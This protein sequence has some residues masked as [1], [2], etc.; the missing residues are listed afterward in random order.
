[1]ANGILKSMTK[2]EKVIQILK[3][4]N[5][6]EASIIKV[7]YWKIYSVHF[8]GENEMLSNELIKIRKNLPITTKIIVVFRYG[9][10]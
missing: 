6:I 1:M 3:I 8:G 5:E 2:A 4:P 9:I 10:N 7:Q